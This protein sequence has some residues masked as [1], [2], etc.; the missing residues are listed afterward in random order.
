MTPGMLDTLLEFHTNE[1]R[2]TFGQTSAAAAN[3]FRS[4]N[5]LDAYDF[6]P[7]PETGGKPR[8]TAAQQKQILQGF[9]K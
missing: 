1:L 3:A 9:K 6:F 4:G 2:R 5:F 8:Q 7:D